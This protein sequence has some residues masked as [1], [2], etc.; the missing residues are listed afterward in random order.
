MQMDTPL[1]AAGSSSPPTIPDP[2]GLFL[3]RFQLT[4]LIE[5]ADHQEGM[6]VNLN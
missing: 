5:L 6:G 1:K 3:L 4:L 2:A